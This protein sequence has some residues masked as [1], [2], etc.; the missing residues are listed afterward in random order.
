MIRRLHWLDWKDVD[1]WSAA[2]TRILADLVRAGYAETQRRDPTPRERDRY[3]IP[4]DAPK[5]KQAKLT[6]TGKLAHMML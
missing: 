4:K 1:E 3:R 6:F 2:D 5:V